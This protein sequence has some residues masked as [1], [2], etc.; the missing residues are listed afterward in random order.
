MY[1]AGYGMIKYCRCKSCTEI[2]KKHQLDGTYKKWLRES[3][4]LNDMK[5]DNWVWDSNL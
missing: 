3:K 2:R 4:I 1:R 5:F